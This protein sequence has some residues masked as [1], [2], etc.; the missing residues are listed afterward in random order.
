MTKQFAHVD[1]YV[2][3]KVFNRHTGPASQAVVV[4]DYLAEQFDPVSAAGFVGGATLGAESQFLPLQIAFESLPDDVPCWGAAYRRHVL[5]W[6]HLGVVRI[7]PDALPYAHHTIDLDP[8]HRDR[9]SL[10]M[11]VVRLTYD[12]MPNELRQADYFERKSAEIL[13]AMGAVKTWAGPRFTGVCSSHDLGGCRMSDD[14]AA[15][16]VDRELQVHDTPGLYVFSGAV[17]PTCP[18]INPTLTLWALTSFAAGRLVER[19][20]A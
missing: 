5:S 15:G 8:V 10:G 16:V 20:S 11:P 14:P 17:F 19:L 7:Q 13:E 12:L 6:Q 18:G 2:P 1:G 3:D 4:D 9:S